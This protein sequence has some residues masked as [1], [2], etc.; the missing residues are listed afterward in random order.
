MPVEQQLLDAVDAALSNNVTTS[1]TTAS[2]ANDVF[3]AYVW[4]LMIAAARGEGALVSFETVGGTPANQLV[5]RTSPGN[6]YSI[7]NQYTHGILN[8]RVCNDVTATCPELE[9]H[10]GVYVAGKSPS[11][12]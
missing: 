3:E 12:T 7:H 9:V 2:A 10:I 8:F 1:Y 6:I 5:F 4:S 11:S